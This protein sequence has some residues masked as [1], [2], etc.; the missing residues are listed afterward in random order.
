MLFNVLLF[1]DTYVIEQE[2]FE[3]YNI[4][5][6]ELPLRPIDYLKRMKAARQ[7]RFR[8][9]REA[10]Q[11]KEWRALGRLKNVSQHQPAANVVQRNTC[12]CVVCLQVKRYLF[13]FPDVRSVAGV[14]ADLIDLVQW[15]K[16]S[17]LQL[18]EAEALRKKLSEE[19]MKADRQHAE[20]ESRVKPSEVEHNLESGTSFLVHKGY[21][22][23]VPD[24]EVLDATFQ[25][26]A[27]DAAA[28]AA[29]AKA[30][31]DAARKADRAADAAYFA[32]A[33]VHNAVEADEAGKVVK[34]AAPGVQF[35]KAAAVNAAKVRHRCM[36]LAAARHRRRHWHLTC[37]PCGTQCSLPP[38]QAQD[39]AR[40]TSRVL[41]HPPEQLM[42]QSRTELN[43]TSRVDAVA[44]K[45]FREAAVRAGTI[46]R[47][48]TTNCISR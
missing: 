26:A 10:A 38:C 2:D 28:K 25:A 48:S 42:T 31:Q 47:W 44:R 16:R 8:I 41:Y 15:R 1:T 9:L 20:A 18:A 36:T 29:A 45:L 39:L 11:Q 6:G 46:S 33:K 24:T 13:T 19:A 12:S 21:Q 32:A 14:I 40:K 22:I 35:A 5:H 43:W 7:E 4:K 30:A 23:E 27:A 34:N 37:T 3:A 17:Q